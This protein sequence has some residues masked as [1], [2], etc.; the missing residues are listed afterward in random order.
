MSFLERVV[1]ALF[2]ILAVAIL[3]ALIRYTMS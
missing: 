3:V 1:T 2:A